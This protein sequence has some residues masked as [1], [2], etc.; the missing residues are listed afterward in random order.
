MLILIVIS[1]SS[2][3]ARFQNYSKLEESSEEISELSA[4]SLN[5][6]HILEDPEDVSS[7]TRKDLL[8][9][10]SEDPGKNYVEND[11]MLRIVFIYHFLNA[12]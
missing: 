7:G 5:V 8:G 6:K 12:C 2:I 11:K 4:A 10:L 1:Q 3:L 9:S